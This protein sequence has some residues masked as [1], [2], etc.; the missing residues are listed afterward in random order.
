MVYHET[1]HGAPTARKQ[2]RRKKLGDVGH[3]T[4][5]LQLIYLSQNRDFKLVDAAWIHHYTPEM[6]E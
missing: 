6:M 2:P 3:S 4:V 1:K 5:P